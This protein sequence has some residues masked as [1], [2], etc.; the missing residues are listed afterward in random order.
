MKTIE[1]E[2]YLD[3]PPDIVWDHV[4]QPKLLH[5]LA[6]GMIT[7]KPINPAEF[8]ERWTNGRY[9][10]RMYWRGWLPIGWQVI[11]IEHFPD[12][13]PLKR[14]RDNG[15]GR[16]I[17][18]WDHMIEVEP[19]GEGTR[20]ADRVKIDAGLMTPVVAAFA[21]RFYAHRQKRLQRLVAANFDF[22]M[23]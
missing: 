18:K 15:Y 6:D 16:G 12:K 3:A 21:R 23:V 8:P 14:M 13:A 20:Y 9:K 5:F 7:F 4:L 11:G 22:Q 10:V 1:L 17:R 2:T 19:K